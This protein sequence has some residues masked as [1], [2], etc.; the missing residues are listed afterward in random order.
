MV[1]IEQVERCV[2]MLISQHNALINEA[3]QHASYAVI[4][5]S[6]R[7]PVN[8]RSG[9][10]PVVAARAS[11]TAASSVGVT[12]ANGFERSTYISDISR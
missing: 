8:L 5:A 12:T 3:S 7:H 6:T 1:P 10:P 2:R 4:A 9:G 11:N